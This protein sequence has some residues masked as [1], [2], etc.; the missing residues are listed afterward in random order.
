MDKIENIDPILDGVSAVFYTHSH[1]DHVG[2]EAV[3]D[4]KGIPQYIGRLSKKLLQLQRGNIL[5]YHPTPE[6][7]ASKKAI[8]NFTTYEANKPIKICDITITPYYVSHSAP[9]A[10]MFVVECDGRTVLHTGDFREHGYRGKGLKPTIQK[11]IVPRNI[12]VLVIEGTMLGRDD[13]RMISEAT[14]YEEL[15]ELMRKYKYVF[16][17]C[18]SQDADRISSINHAVA[19]VGG[20]RML[21]DGY[22][23][24]VLEAFEK[25][26][27]QGNFLCYQYKR[28]HYFRKNW[29]NVLDKDCK[30]GFAM[31]VRNNCNFRKAL[32]EMM[33]LL[34]KEQCCLVYSQFKGYITPKHS[35]FMQNTY[36][37]IHTFDWHFMYLH[38]SGHASRETLEMVCKNVKPKMAIIP[39]HREARSDFRELN[40]SEELKNKVITQ[41][42]SIEDIKIVVK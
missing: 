21:V 10:Y 12:D 39:I 26:L 18:T 38:T 40:L 33:P 23:Y 28:K 9:D 35:A 19:T 31:L 27:G 36:D 37:F 4:K 32:D 22:Q 7:R 34:D 5:Y 20:R 17:M 1:G 30:R 3:I 14:L 25:E 41:S 8:D 6:L 11:Y 15:T 24:K 2:F 16:V 29:S 13:S 42:T